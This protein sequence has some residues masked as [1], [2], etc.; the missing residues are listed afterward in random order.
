MV[1]S[2]L[3]FNRLSAV[4]N[5]KMQKC[6]LSEIIQHEINKHESFALSK[7]M[8]FETDI[9][10]DVFVNGNDELLAIAVGNYLSNAVRHSVNGT[11]IKIKL[12]RDSKD[13][14]FEIFNKSDP[15]DTKKDIWSVLTKG[16]ASRGGS[17]GSSGMGL[18]VCKRI[19][20]L[21]KMEYGYKNEDHGVKFFFK[22]KTF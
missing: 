12:V 16:D 1:Q 15:I 11:K 18:P 20:E 10:T 14:T 4:G 5:I 7:E 19:F 9:Q 3:M 22:G 17:D 13:F 8:N 2:F 6:C 21:N